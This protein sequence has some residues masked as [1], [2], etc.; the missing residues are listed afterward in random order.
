MTLR[1]TASFKRYPKLPFLIALFDLFNGIKKELAN[2]L[3]LKTAMTGNKVATFQ[4][5]S[6][7]LPRIS[8]LEVLAA[9]PLNGE[10]FILLC[11]QKL[12]NMRLL[13]KW[14]NPC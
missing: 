6:G 3:F 10:H 12:Q 9:L 8:P 13:A 2:K 7:L 11:Q 1:K 14:F 4:S 5:V